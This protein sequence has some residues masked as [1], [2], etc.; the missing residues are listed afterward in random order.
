[1]PRLHTWIPVSST[2]GPSSHGMGE[3]AGWA[4]T[5]MG[6][7]MAA[8]TITS[9]MG[10]DNDDAAAYALGHMMTFPDYIKQNMAERPADG[11][12]PLG[13]IRPTGF[14]VDSYTV[15]TA[16]V[17]LTSTGTMAGSSE[18]STGV[19]T[20]SLKWVEGDWKVVH[21]PEDHPRWTSTPS[22]NFVTWGPP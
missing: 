15:A 11:Q 4:Q 21:T 19:L 22:G 18:V 12:A 9:A 13:T 1:M 6:A 14:R 2:H 17:S 20:A 16:T 7:V 3:W 10:Q 5:P 8:H